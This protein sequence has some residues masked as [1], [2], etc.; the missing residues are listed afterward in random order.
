MDPLYLTTPI[1]YANAEPHLGHTYTTVVADVLARFWR[2][3]GRR[4]FRTTGTDEHGD[5]IAAA[6]AKAGVAPKA[7]VDRISARFR[8][9]W[10]A[11]GLACEA[12]VRTTDPYHVEFVRRILADIHAKGDIYFGSYRG[13]YCTGCERF[14]QERE[15]VDGLCPDHRVAPV[16][17]A[18]ENYFFRMQAYQD[19]LRALVE[20]RPELITPEGYRREVLAL[21]R[22]PIGDLC[23]SRP[24]SRLTWG[25]ELPFDDRYVTY[26]WFDA[27]L[28]YV[29]PL[30]HL[31]LEDELWPHAHH[32]IAKDILKPHAIYWPTMLMAAGL[33]LYRAL[34][35]HG[36]WQMAAGKMSK[37]LGNVVRP[38]DVKARY[39]MD[40]FRYYLLRDMAFGQDAEFSEAALVA[41]LNGDLANG[42]G[43]LA[44][45]VLRM[46]QSY[47]GGVIQPRAPEPADDALRAAFAAARPDVDAHVADLG[48]HR[49]L[50]ALWRA[51][52]HA[53][54]YVTE[55]APFTL[56]KDPARR[57]RV[58]AILHELCEALRVT[59][60]L[61]EPFLPESARKLFAMLGLPDERLATLDV[62][63]GSAFPPGH[64]THAPEPL[65]PRVEV[66][67]E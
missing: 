30:V 15:L 20:G 59:A 57:P 13:L 31:G 54:K 35:V 3:R 67:A 48:F 58:G 62:P 7:F 50:E 29:S 28:S 37:S 38:L 24:K 46:Q 61:V 8:S 36:Y 17:I 32:V 63:W 6:A 14:Y 4:V 41:R 34:R 39:G 25:I 65:F 55:T 12:F 27:L 10:E 64:R 60:Q 40:A 16:E 19:R 45:R 9:T 56:A 2:A 66:P 49:A 5:K 18:E 42:L 44:S 26:V 1:Y 11:T 22:E 47:F 23:I 33:P 21:L 43:N 53:N 52:D 51:L